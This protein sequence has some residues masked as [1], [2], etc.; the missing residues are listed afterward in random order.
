MKKILSVIIAV[1]MIVLLTGCSQSGRDDGSGYVAPESANTQQATTRTTEPPTQAPTTDYSTKVTRVDK[2]SLIECNEKSLKSHAFN[3]G[4]AWATLKSDTDNNTVYAIINNSGEILYILDNS[5][6]DKNTITTP[7]IKG[8]S[9]VYSTTSSGFIIVS[10]KGKE[11]FSP[12]EDNMYMCGQASD[13]SFIIG[14]KESGFEKVAWHLFVLDSSLNLVDTGIEA[15]EKA[16]NLTEGVQYVTDGIYYLKDYILNLNN[17]SYFTL[18]N[19]HYRHFISW[20]NGYGLADRYG[21]YF[22]FNLDDI[23]NASSCDE[24]FEIVEK[25]NESLNKKFCPEGAVLSEIKLLS[26]HGGSLFR[27]YTMNSNNTT[28]NDYIDLNGNIIYEYP[29][30]P[31]TTRYKAIDY[32][33]GEYCALYLVGADNN[34]YVT[35]SDEQANLSYEPVLV[36]TLSGST[37]NF[38]T[39][40]DHVC[41]CNGYIFIYSILNHTLEIVN[42][43]GEFVKLGDDLSGLKDATFTYKERFTLGIGGDYILAVL[44]DGSIKYYSVDGDKTIET[45]TANYNDNGDLVYNDN[46]GKKTVNTANKL[47]R[48]SSDETVAPAEVS[49]NAPKS[50]TTINRF[51]II[52]KWKNVGTYTFGQAQKGSIISFDGTNCNFF[53]PKDTYAFYKDGENYKLDCTNPLADT[54]SFTVKIIDENNIDIYNGT[55][56]VELTRVE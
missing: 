52:G 30:F 6:T 31:E 46:D 37:G 42:P 28:H 39:I 10:D 1:V 53:S 40:D 7:F 36:R 45:I 21:A 27:K 56:I 41:S 8:L 50:Y 14:Q 12:S 35:I 55:N 26:W 24:F 17:N 38:S 9:A 19:S 33:S 49:T 54:V 20:N 34:M 44:Y 5:K 22:L 18:A 51:S 4:V 2:Y 16:I 47:Q 48:N 15:K 23:K 32:F 29:T 25:D 13:G 3:N 11:V 43:K